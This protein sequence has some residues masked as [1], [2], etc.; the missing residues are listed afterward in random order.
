[1]SEEEVE[2]DSSTQVKGKKSSK[3]KSYS[4]EICVYT[5]NHP[6]GI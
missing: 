4:N 6:L 5:N 2:D 1:M 3:S